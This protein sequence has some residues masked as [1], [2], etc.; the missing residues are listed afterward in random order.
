MRQMDSLKLSSGMPSLKDGMVPR[1]ES[2]HER[3]QSLC[4]EKESKQE[5]EFHSVALEKM[6][7]RKEQQHHQQSQEERGT[8]YA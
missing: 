7:E 6:K 5:W 3:I 1:P 4:Q 2:L 8:M